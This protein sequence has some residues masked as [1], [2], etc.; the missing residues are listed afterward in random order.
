MMNR[1]TLFILILSFFVI[2]CQSNKTKN[3]KHDPVKTKPN[4][5]ANVVGG[6]SQSEINEDVKNAANFALQE[7]QSPS[8]IEEILEVKTQIVSGKNYDITFS[9]KNGEKW[10]VVVYRNIKNEYT[11]TKSEKIK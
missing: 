6:W 5:P 8:E 10:N 11:L 9:L 2:A 3:D 7:I 4:K 1:N